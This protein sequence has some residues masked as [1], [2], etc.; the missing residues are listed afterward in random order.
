MADAASQYL[1]HESP[2][3]EFVDDHCNRH[4]FKHMP[5]SGCVKP[6]LRSFSGCYLLLS[7]NMSSMHGDASHSVLY[8]GKTSASRFRMIKHASNPKYANRYRGAGRWPSDVLYALEREFIRHVPPGELDPYKWYED[9]L[10][11]LFVPPLSGEFP[12]AVSGGHNC[13]CVDQVD[14]DLE[15]RTLTWRRP[16]G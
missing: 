10:H 5:F 13:G 4:F 3:I 9:R 11:F 16:T 6:R 12:K 2:E 7:Q 8:A 1:R 14:L 15:H